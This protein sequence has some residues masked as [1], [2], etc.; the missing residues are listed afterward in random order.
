MQ[1]SIK[2]SVETS[3]I[4]FHN[5]FYNPQVALFRIMKNYAKL[6]KFLILQTIVK[7]FA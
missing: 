5:I 2:F 6:L 4:N 3:N 7:N 1:N